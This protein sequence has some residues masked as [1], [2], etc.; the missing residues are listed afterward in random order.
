MSSYPYYR[1]TLSVTAQNRL[2][3]KK[4]ATFKHNNNPR[5]PEMKGNVFIQNPSAKIPWPKEEPVFF[6]RSVLRTMLKCR[7]MPEWSCDAKRFHWIY[8][9]NTKTSNNFHSGEINESLLPPTCTS[10]RQLAEFPAAS[11]AV[12]RKIRSLFVEMPSMSGGTY[13][14]TPT[15]SEKTGL[16]M[17]TQTG[18]VLKVTLK[19]FSGQKTTFGLSLSDE[20]KNC[21]CSVNEKYCRHCYFIFLILFY[22]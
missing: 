17:F 14:T 9:K 21:T 7:K 19:I 1:P 15:L 2:S 16:V 22:T 11:Y 5:L 3:R 18:S 8:S 12:K 6:D 10:T 13:L 4:E 20:I